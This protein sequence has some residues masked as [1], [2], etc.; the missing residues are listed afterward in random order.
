MN[1]FKLQMGAVALAFA[2]AT[3][4]AAPTV[5]EATGF[6]F[7]NPDSTLADVLVSDVAGATTIRFSDF[8]NSMSLN[9]SDADGNAYSADMTF[10]VRA[11]Y[12]VTGYS[13]SASF[14]GTLD[15][16]VP[17]G[18][19]AGAGMASN[20]GSVSLIASGAN[21]W[22][23]QGNR[24]VNK[25]NGND[26]FVFSAANLTLR[27]MLTISLN[28]SMTLF[29]APAVWTTPDGVVQRQDSWAGLSVLNPTLTVYTTAVPEPETYAM[30]ALGLAVIGLTRRTRLRL[31]DSVAQA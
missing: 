8:A 23:N 15:P 17:P 3:A 5:I 7:T 13:F 25:L 26:S 29:A 31:Q 22:S 21:D 18:G 20:R 12:Q 24:S 27:D 30:L 28:S 4:S 1:L 19:G 2:S 16:A 14:A 9:T 10:A 6:T 11:G